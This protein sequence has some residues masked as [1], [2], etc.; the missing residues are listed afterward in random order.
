MNRSKWYG[1]LVAAAFWFPCGTAAAADEPARITA[2][3]SW[4]DHEGGTL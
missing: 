4:I 1:C 2:A 3:P